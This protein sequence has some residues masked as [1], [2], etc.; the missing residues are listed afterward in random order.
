VNLPLECYRA[1]IAARTNADE[2]WIVTGVI[3]T[4]RAEAKAA[5][6]PG[7]LDYAAFADWLDAA[8]QDAAF[9]YRIGLQAECDHDGEWVQVTEPERGFPDFQC[10]KCGKVE[11]RV[12]R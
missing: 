11:T 9:A 8:A 4:Y 7:A 2:A 1:W 10:P 5:K 12:K 3:E 6:L